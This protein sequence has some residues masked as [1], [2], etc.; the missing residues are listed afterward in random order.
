MERHRRGIKVHVEVKPEI[1]E[2]FQ[3]HG[4]GAKITAQHGRLWKTVSPDSPPLQFW[5]LEQNIKDA[6]Y[7]IVRT[8]VD[9]VGR[10]TGQLNIAF[11][12][13]VGAS[14]PGG[15]EFLLDSV[16]STPELRI[17]GGKIV[18][19]G[20]KFYMDY[21]QRVNLQLRVSVMDVTRVTV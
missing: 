15:R 18:K 1:E 19:A 11:L 8:G 7:D 20:E 13:L 2:F 14:E 9:L 21:I 5:S 12:R 6:V 16:I 17:L 4:G 10:D 3:L